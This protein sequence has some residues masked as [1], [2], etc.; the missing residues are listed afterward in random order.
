VTTDGD[1]DTDDHTFSIT[2]DSE[3][4]IEGTSES[5]AIVGSSGADTILGGDGDDT[6]YA[7]D[8]VA[9]VIDGG[10]GTDTAYVDDA[11]L[12]QDLIDN[13]ENVES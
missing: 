1:Y 12:L 7:D 13:V 8:G 11:D 9:D 5:D 2:F 6:I 10:N 4:P 3:N